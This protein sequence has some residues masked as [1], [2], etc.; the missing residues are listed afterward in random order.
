MGS[1]IE[2]I[3]FGGPNY[4]R[5]RSFFGRRIQSYSRVSIDAP[6]ISG[7]S[8]AGLVWQKQIVG[9]NYGGPEATRSALSSRGEPI[10]LVYPASSSADAEFLGRWLTQICRP[11]GCRPQ[12]GGIYVNPSSPSASPRGDDQFYPPP[13]QPA[14]PVNEPSEQQRD[15]YVILQPTNLEKIKQEII[16]SLP[17]PRD[18]RDGKDGQRGPAGAPATI[19]EQQIR[20]IIARVAAQMPRQSLDL[21]AITA[22]VQARLPPIYPMWVDSQGNTIDEIPGGVRLGQTMPLRID[23]IVREARDANTGSQ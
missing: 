6:T 10:P 17:K 5:L 23:S 20:E 13:S 22:E 9:V 15:K 7:D 4:G 1:E 18:G 11:W 3:G 14:Q 2:L 12:I 21:E 8:G 16:A 19:T